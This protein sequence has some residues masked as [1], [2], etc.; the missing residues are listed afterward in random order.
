MVVV[1]AVVVAVVLVVTVVV[2]LALTLALAL[3]LIVILIVKVAVV[4]L[5]I[6]L[7]NGSIT[8]FHFTYDPF[9]GLTK[10]YATLVCRDF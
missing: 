4:P 6:L 10:D 9:L 1:I 5:E 7:N 2:A 3:A 8:R